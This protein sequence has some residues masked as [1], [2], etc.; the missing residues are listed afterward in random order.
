MCRQYFA[1]S[2]WLPMSPILRTAVSLIALCVAPGVV[3]A[4]EATSPPV[5]LTHDQAVEDVQL[6]I[7]AFEAALPKVCAFSCAGMPLG[8]LTVR[9]P[10]P[11]WPD[12]TVR[13]E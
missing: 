3:M 1:Y 8:R 9:C 4:Q 13:I 10:S 6:A 2:R 5:V 7:D 12:R 11:I